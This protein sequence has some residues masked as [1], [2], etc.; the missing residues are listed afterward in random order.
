[1]MCGAGGKRGIG[2]RMSIGIVLALFL[3]AGPVVQ[4]VWAGAAT[5]AMKGSIDELLRVVQDKDLR[6]PAKTSERRKLLEQTVSERFDFEEMSLRALGAPWKQLSDQDKK[7]FV[8]LFRTLLINTYR[9]QIETY[10]GDGVQYLNERVEK[11]GEKEYA[12]VRTKIFLSDKSELRLDYKLINKDKT[13][14]RVYDVVIQDI[15]LISNY[16]K[17]FTKIIRASSYQGLVDQL[18]TKS[19]KIKAP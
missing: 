18:R 17:Q 6:Q 8:S 1:M 11:A 14:W 19:D 9:E 13:N 3:C 12:E 7:E 15:G 2:R 10:S 16:Q 5:D 4:T